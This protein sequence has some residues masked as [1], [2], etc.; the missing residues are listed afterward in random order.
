MAFKDIIK[1]GVKT[2]TGDA[3]VGGV[4]HASD[5][6]GGFV[7]E[8]F[9]DRARQKNY[10]TNEKAADNADKRQ[11]AQYKDLYSPE[12]MIE[13]YKAAGLSPSM[14]MSGG[15]SAVGGSAAGNMSGGAGGGY[16]SAG[17]GI[18][19]LQAQLMK[20][21]IDN[22][23]A[24][25]DMKLTDNAIR[26]IDK[27]IKE[28]EFGKMSKEFTILNLNLMQ[29]DRAVTYREL[30]NESDKFDTFVNKVREAMKYDSGNLHTINSE[31][32]QEILRSIYMANKSLNNDIAVLSSSE[33][34]AKFQE[35][36]TN[37]LNSEGYAEQNAKTAVQ[38][39]RTIAA[40]G[41]LTEQQKNAWNNLLDKLGEGTMKDIL[42][43]LAMVL[44]KYV[45]GAHVAINTG[46]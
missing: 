25:T 35:S 8:F 9:A 1:Q 20:A 30:A 38:Q 2:I 28:L 41:E 24:D 18:A 11:R 22:I 27:Q 26:N 4:K 32:G 34:S 39:L 21:N 10:E 40:E 16:P 37:W 33:V 5:F 7:N 43:V 19:G 17:N 14:M 6:V 45:G 13:Q 42:I 23:N 44:G 15:Q 46:R 3:Y 29:G 31:F 12:A 36:I